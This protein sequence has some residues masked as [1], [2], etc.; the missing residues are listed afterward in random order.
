MFQRWFVSCVAL[1]LK[2]LLTCVNNCHPKKM[3]AAE[4]GCRAPRLISVA[5]AV[6]GTPNRDRVLPQPMY[7]GEKRRPEKVSCGVMDWADGCQYLGTFLGQIPHG[8]GCFRYDTH[9][10]AKKG[11]SELKNGCVIEGRF[12]QSQVRRHVPKTD[13]A[14]VPLGGDGKA[15]RYSRSR[16]RVVA[17]ARR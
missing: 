11:D 1:H 2:C 6:G 14:A 13:M 16:R 7:M 15:P 12:Y 10:E 4:F 8:H 5:A 3:S 9:P 17:Q